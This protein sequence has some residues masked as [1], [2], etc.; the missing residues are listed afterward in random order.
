MQR[1]SIGPDAAERL[2][3]IPLFE[4]VSLGQRRMLGRLVD[5]LHADAGETIMEEGSLGYEFMMI[6]EGEA[7]VLQNGAH[8]CVLGP[9]DFCGELAIINDGIPRTASVIARTDMRGLVFTA[10]FL[11]EIRQLVPLVGERID[12]QARTR[13]ERDAHVGA[14]EQ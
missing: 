12:D 13:L 2:G 4:G 3:L 6:E 8:V 1:R 10:H 5:E 14:A 9:G 7:E 11:R